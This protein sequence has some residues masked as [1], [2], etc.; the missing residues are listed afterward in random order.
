MKYNKLERKIAFIL[1]KF[2]GLKLAIKKVYQRLNYLRYKKNYYFKSDYKITKL[3]YENKESFFGYYDKSPINISNEYIIFQTSN[4][5]TKKL[6]NPNVPVDLVLYDIKND[7]YEIIDESYSYN[8]QQGT[9]LMWLSEDEF[10]YNNYDKNRDIYI[11]KIYNVQT[12]EFKVVDF[13]IYDCYEN[14]FS[15]SLNFDRLNIG[16][17]DYSYSN[18]N[19][20]VNWDDNANDGLYYLDLQSNNTKLIMSLET[21]IKLNYKDTMQNAK[22]KFNHIMISPNGK[23]FMFMH[24]WF[25]KDNRRYDTLYVSNID[26]SK[27]QIIAD[28]DMVSHCY[29]YDDKNIFAYLRDKDMGDKYYLIDIGTF[30]KTIVGD[31]LIDNFGDGHPSINNEKILFDTYPNKARMKELFIFNKNK[32]ELLNIG[33]SF[34]SF[35]FY[36]ETRCDLHP[37]FSFDGKKIFFDSVHSGKRQLYMMDIS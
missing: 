12:K 6:P 4:T 8:W 5:D 36:S 28:D 33:E 1:T 20:K 2:P 19:V 15:I 13:P 23:K 21:I 3:T 32:L 11:S 31:G 35:D 30:K 14:R 17:A 16:R 29:W 27:I 22:H 37:R 26:G 18:R 10:I 7:K 24:R 9:K 34:E 25:T